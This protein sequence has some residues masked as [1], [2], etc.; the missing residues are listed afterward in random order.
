MAKFRIGSMLLTIRRA[1][2]C[3]GADENGLGKEVN[4]LATA[5]V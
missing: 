5:V 3:D 2:G 1:K 4:Y